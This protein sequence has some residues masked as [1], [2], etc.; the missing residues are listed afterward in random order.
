MFFSQEDEGVR[1]QIKRCLVQMREFFGQ[2]PRADSCSRRVF[3]RALWLLLYTTYPGNYLIDHQW[4]S[5]IRDG[6]S[7]CDHCIQLF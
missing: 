3:N 7:S 5:F 2:V 4:I 6:S 1:V